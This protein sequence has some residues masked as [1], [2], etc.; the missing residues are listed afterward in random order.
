WQRCQLFWHPTSSFSCCCCCCRNGRAG[1][2]RLRTFKQSHGCG[3][4]SWRWYH[5]SR[6]S[7][8]HRLF[9]WFLAPLGRLFPSFLLSRLSRSF[10]LGFRLSQRAA[11]LSVALNVTGQVLAK[12]SVE[13]F[14]CTGVAQ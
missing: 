10:H 6:A 9:G 11:Q 12:F 7:A 4:L 14:R 3:W 2:S 5:R 8:G 13:L 1:S